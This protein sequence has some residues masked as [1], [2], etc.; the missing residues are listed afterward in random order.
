MMLNH[1]DEQIP[2]RKFTS[3]F[4]EL[5][6]HNSSVSEGF[7]EDDNLRLRATKF[8]HKA[9]TVSFEYTPLHLLHL[10]IVLEYLLTTLIVTLLKILRMHTQLMVNVQH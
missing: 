8:R 3:G 10:F 1:T 7:I 9:V 5:K 4:K 6:L 2:Q